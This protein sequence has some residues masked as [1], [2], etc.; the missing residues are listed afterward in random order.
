VNLRLEDGER[1]LSGIVETQDEI[2]ANRAIDAFNELAREFLTEPSSRQAA[3]PTD[4]RLLVWDDTAST[5]LPHDPSHVD[6]P[7]PPVEVD[8]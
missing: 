8:E 7:R 5:W 6:Q 3:E 2:I 4:R 1:S